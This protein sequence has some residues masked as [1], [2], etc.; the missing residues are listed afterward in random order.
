[1]AN[2][3]SLVPVKTR[4]ALTEP[5]PLTQCFGST[6]SKVELTTFGQSHH[7]V[8]RVSHGTARTK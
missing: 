6:V 8:R 2:Y 7:S 4:S 3:L 5:S 1:M